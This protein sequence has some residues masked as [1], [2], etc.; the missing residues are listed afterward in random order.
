MSNESREFALSDEQENAVDRMLSGKNVFLTGKA[1]TGKSTIIREFQ[2]RCDKQVMCLAPT[3]M[4]ANLIGGSTIHNFFGFNIGVLN[5]DQLE[6][7]S[8]IQAKILRAVDTIIAD[9]VSM[10][11]SDAFQSMDTV[12]RQ[13]CDKD[14]PFG[15]KQIITVGDFM[16]LPPVVAESK[17][18]D[19]LEATYGGI[20]S[21]CTPAWEQAEFNPIN[22][23]NVHR[24]NDMR[25]LRSANA[26]RSGIIKSSAPNYL[27]ELNEICYNPDRSHAED[28]VRLCCTKRQVRQINDLELS[29]LPG[30]VTKFN[31]IVLGKFPKG[32]YPT[33]RQ[34]SLKRGAKVMLLANKRSG[35]GHAYSNGDVGV[36]VDYA[37]KR[38]C[39]TIMVGLANGKVIAVERTMWTHYEYALDKSKRI[40]TQKKVGS[41]VQYPLVPAFAWTIHKAQ[42]RTLPKAHLTLES[43]CF[44]HGQAYVALT[45]VRSID[46]LTFGRPL[47]E[48]DVIVD[49][50]VRRFYD[51]I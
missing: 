45:R 50:Q 17:V 19:Y 44:C 41:F 2:K 28:S 23:R 7:L 24:Q 49:P 3:G 38:N 26:I 37:G 48:Q 32:Y 34:L 11:R 46:D 15:G 35:N 5:K 9:E 43:K 4:A 12:L 33:D 21:F 13:A 47:E 6:P 16:Q 39:H 51:S 8:P 25:L 30:H 1:G 40:I 29:W 22:L 14:L 10:I 42:G 27:K 20:F 31:A 18:N 36:V